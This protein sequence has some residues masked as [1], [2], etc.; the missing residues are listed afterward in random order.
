TTPPRRARGRGQVLIRVERAVTR[1]PAAGFRVGPPKASAGVR[2]VAMPPHASRAIPDHLDEHA[3]PG[4]D[5]LLVP[6]RSGQHLAESTFVDYWYP[7]RAAAGR[8]DTPW[9]ALRH[10]G[11][12][13]YALTGA[14]LAEI[15]ARAGHSTHLAAMRYQ[16]TAGRDAELAARMGASD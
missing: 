3:Q 9:H 13:R 14:T 12:T 10:F 5:G 1:V 16:H 15:Q 2:V 6:A 11:L 8:D 7:A 4:P